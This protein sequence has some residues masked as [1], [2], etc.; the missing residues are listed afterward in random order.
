MEKIR[1]L[2][3]EEEIVKRTKEIAEELRNIYSLTE[4][5]RI[6]MAV[7]F[8]KKIGQLRKD[9]ITANKK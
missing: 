4:R 1:V 5:N 2:F 3:K 8:D 9:F 7:D 6:K